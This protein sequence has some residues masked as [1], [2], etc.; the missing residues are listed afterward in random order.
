[1]GRP[2]VLL[3]D[4]P[5]AGMNPYETMELAGQVRA[6]R[7]RGVNVLLIEHHMQM[8]MEISDRVVVM[9][10]GVRI[11]EGAPAE[12][13]RDPLVIEAYLGRRAAARAG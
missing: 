10:H 4:E 9:D 12:V 5:A 7:D 3:L 6:I 1:M 13:A 8:V 11:A 2:R